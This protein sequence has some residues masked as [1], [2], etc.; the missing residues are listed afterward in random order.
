VP[1]V[2]HTHQTSSFDDAV[3]MCLTIAV[4]FCSSH[5]L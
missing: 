4:R 5:L 3:A 1:D 2:M